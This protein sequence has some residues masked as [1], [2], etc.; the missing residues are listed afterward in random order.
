[1]NDRIEDYMMHT[2]FKELA[3]QAGWM[4]TS[5]HPRWNELYQCQNF[6]IGEFAE[7][8]VQECANQALKMGEAHSLTDFYTGSII[9]SEF[10]LARFGVE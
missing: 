4:N 9:L 5:Q 6:D 1:M 8:I 2:K 7:L 10:L 3:K